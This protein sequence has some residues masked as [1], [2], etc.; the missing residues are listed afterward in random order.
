MATKFDDGSAM[1]AKSTNKLY[2]RTEACLIVQD[3]A[4][5]GDFAEA[6][7]GNAMR[8]TELLVEVIW[9]VPMHAVAVIDIRGEMLLGK[10]QH[11]DTVEFLVRADGWACYKWPKGVP[12]GAFFGKWY[13][14]AHSHVRQH[15]KLQETWFKTRD[16]ELG[17][18]GYLRTC[19][20]FKF[21][22]RRACV[23]EYRFAQRIY[24]AKYAAAN[25]HL[26]AVWETCGALATGVGADYTRCDVFVGGDGAV[27]VNEIS[28]S[29]YWGNTLSD[30]WQRRFLDL[31]LAGYDAAPDAGGAAFHRTYS[32]PLPSP[33]YRGPP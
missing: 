22:E 8:P 28:L 33:T 18:R 21:F 15:R 3:V 30:A 31:W 16:P 19:A 13:V 17:D 11:Q 5:P 7:D 27:S 24:W 26:T 6:A 23:R 29:S 32:G 20:G 1:W 4:N 12:P 10:P 14:N 25:P 9:G 2:D